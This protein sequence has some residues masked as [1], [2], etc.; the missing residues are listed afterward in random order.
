MKNVIESK[1][2]SSKKIKWGANIL[3]HLKKILEKLNNCSEN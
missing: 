3:K 1:I 2:Q